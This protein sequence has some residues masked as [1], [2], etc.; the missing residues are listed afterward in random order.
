MT[1]NLQGQ[2]RIGLSRCKPWRYS[3]RTP[4]VHAR[5]PQTRAGLGNSFFVREHANEHRYY[6]VITVTRGGECILNYSPRAHSFGRL[7]ARSSAVVTH[8]V[9]AGRAS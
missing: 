8:R 9:P 2:R 4:Q 6:D 3:E 5:E 7:P 1:C